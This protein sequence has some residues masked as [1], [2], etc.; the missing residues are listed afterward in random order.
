MSATVTVIKNH[1]FECGLSFSMNSFIVFTVPSKE[2][3]CS[4][5]SKPFLVRYLEQ[6]YIHVC[7]QDRGTQSRPTQPATFLIQSCP[8]AAAAAK[9][10]QSCPT[11]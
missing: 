6:V 3:F 2:P 4:K 1:Y 9:L 5:V 10:L 7:A 8:A 11:L